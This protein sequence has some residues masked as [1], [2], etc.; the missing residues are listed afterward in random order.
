M[1][2]PERVAAFDLAD[3]AQTRLLG[4]VL[5]R[6]LAP[7]AVIALEGPLGSGKTTLVSGLLGALGSSTPAASPTFNLLHIHPTQPPVYHFDA[8]RLTR[9][10]DFEGMGAEDYLYG[11]GISI[12][13]WAGKVRQYMPAESIWIEMAHT[14]VGRSARISLRGEASRFFSQFVAAAADVGIICVSGG[15]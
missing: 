14:A 9:P 6:F 2:T 7:G 8:W 4:A 10:E 13:E 3:S 15:C 1:S 12:V 5:A 11:S